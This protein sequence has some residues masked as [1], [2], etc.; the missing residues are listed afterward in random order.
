MLWVLLQDYEMAEEE[1]SRKLMT[2]LISLPTDPS[3]TYD[4]NAAQLLQDLQ[5]QDAKKLLEELF[6]TVSQ[7]PSEWQGFHCQSR[8][9]SH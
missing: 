7:N 5:S 2:L 1:E 6:M 3:K 4:I 9:H 8:V